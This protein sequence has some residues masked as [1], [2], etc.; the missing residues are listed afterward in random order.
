MNKLLNRS[1]SNFA[2]IDGIRAIAVLWV[3]FFHAWLF[4]QLTIPGFIDNVYKY[5]LFYW[6]TKGD[7]GVDLFFVISGFLIGGI[8]FKEIQTRESFN[9]KRFYVRRFLRLSPV[10]IFAIFLNLYFLK[11]F[12][13]DNLLKYWPNL[14]YINN[15]VP[16]SPMGWTWSLAIEEQFYIVVPFLL[17]FVFPKFRNKA[18]FFIILSA[19]SISLS[20][21]YV[22]VLK[23][24]TLPFNL[25]FFTKEW[26]DW[27]EGYYVLTHLRYIG[28]LLGVAAAYV[29]VYKNDEIKNIFENR[30]GLI[31]I[32]SALSVFIVIFLSFT[33]VGEFMPLKTSIFYNLNIHVGRW[34]EILTRPTFSLSIA[35]III[36]CIHG[37]NFI[38][39]P[40]KKFLS[41]KF[42]YPIA[43]VSYSAYLFHEMFIIWV[44]PR[45]LKYLTPNYS[46]TQIFFITTFISLIVILIVAVIMYYLIEQPFQKIRDKIKFN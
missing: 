13:Q 27:F 24:Y 44:S 34:Y 26:I 6:V 10:Y 11:D 16:G 45:L 38:I 30:K 3:I 4:Q 5:P 46:H 12:N 36:A 43:Q 2:V 35:F 7:L 32:L 22:Y 39:N 42:F 9:F 20:W 15:Y 28:L 19:I 18:A 40:I 31:T 21:Y 8:I 25:T 33:P 17:V 14:L 37:N 23:Q 1:N 29:N 41:L